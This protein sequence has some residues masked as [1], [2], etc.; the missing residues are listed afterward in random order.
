MVII[1]IFVTFSLYSFT[2]EYDVKSHIAII[3]QISDE[4]SIIV[5]FPAN[6]ALL[7]DKDGFYTYTEDS[8]DSTYVTA[9][10]TESGTQS[11]RRIINYRHLISW[12]IDT[13][14]VIKKYP[15]RLNKIVDILN[16]L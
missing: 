5:V 11:M 7:V 10:R 15:S 2:V 8:D 14:P 13:A 12:S 4:Q 6:V 1:G 9:V 3:W 16:A